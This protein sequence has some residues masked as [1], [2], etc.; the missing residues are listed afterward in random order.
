MGSAEDISILLD[1]LLRAL[2]GTLAVAT[3]KTRVVAILGLA[4]LLLALFDFSILWKP[5]W[6]TWNEMGSYWIFMS[7][8]LVIAVKGWIR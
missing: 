7:A 1:G 5:Q 6:T 8:M 4:W 3:A 2:L